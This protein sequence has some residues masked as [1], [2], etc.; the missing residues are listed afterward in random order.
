MGTEEKREPVDLE[1]DPF[2]RRPALG[3]LGFARSTY[4]GWQQWLPQEGKVGLVD[5]HPLPGTGWKRLTPQDETMLREAL[6]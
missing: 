3:E 5:Q 6:R 1:R 2:C 4:C